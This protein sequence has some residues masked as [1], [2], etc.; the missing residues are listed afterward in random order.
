MFFRHPL[1]SIGTVR[2]LALIAFFG[3]LYF[4]VPFMTP[5][6][7]QRNLSLAEIAGLQTTLMLAMLV[8]E[9]PTGVLADRLGHVWSY[10]IA[11][12]VLAS[13]E[14]LFL[15]ARDYWAFLAIQ[16]ITG[17]GFAFGSGSVDAIL[18]DALPT[19][20]RLSLM[21]RAKGLLGGATQ[22]GS[23]VAYSL[24][25]IIAADLTLGRMTITIVLGAAAVATAAMLAFGLREAPHV[26][27]RPRANSR[28]LLGDAW[29]AIRS[30]PPLRRTM[31]LAVVTNAFGAHLLV[32]YQEYFL[33][34]GVPGLWL[35]LGLSLA[36]VLVVITQVMAW[37]LPVKLGTGRA[38]L[39]ATVLPGVLY[40]MMA[41]NGLAWL[42]VVLFIGQWGVIHLSAPL[43][44]GL[45]NIHLP[46]QARATGLSLIS[47][48]VT[49]YVGVGG[50]VLGELAEWSLA[51][52]FAG[53][54]CVIVMGG[55]LCRVGDDVAVAAE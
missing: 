41:I 29:R 17:T 21:Q 2:L 44:A 1:L 31:V 34:T 8:M 48:L 20:D 49:V 46:D 19:G 24:G 54:G 28:A 38:M 40:L 39:L 45:Y 27:E 42:A 32:F 15:F 55:L 30:S 23:V 7:L 47:A 43:F 4:F 18:F 52:T 22:T 26:K 35:G 11:L 16:V 6:L 33:V 36:S 3:Q 14:F 13:G 53:L 10:R 37:R 12:I 51:G 5:Y 9:I 50:V 25:G